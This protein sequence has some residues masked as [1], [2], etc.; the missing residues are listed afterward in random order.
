MPTWYHGD[1]VQRES[2]FGQKMDRDS[3]RD[4]NAVGP[5]I[6]W[7]SDERQAHFSNPLVLEFNTEDCTSYDDHSWKAILSKHFKAKGKR[8]TT[9]LLKAGYDGIVTVGQ[10]EA[11]TKE[12]VSLG[13][14]IAWDVEE[15]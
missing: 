14:N 15:D 5:G 1:A 13:R 2:F 9:K 8:L 6:Y 3:D 4:P 10:D 7:T 11:Y 12:I